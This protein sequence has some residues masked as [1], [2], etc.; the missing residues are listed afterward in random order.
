MPVC[1]S[2]LSCLVGKGGL[3]DL[4]GDN[5]GAD[6][7]NS[8]SLF[9]TKPPARK[10]YLL[11]RP[12]TLSMLLARLCDL[13]LLLIASLRGGGSGLGSHCQ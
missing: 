11:R 5:P 2:R 10:R 7:G 9:A 4:V 1:V 6:M 13:L 12:I 8:A 3:T